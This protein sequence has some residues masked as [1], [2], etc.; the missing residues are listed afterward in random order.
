M[1]FFLRLQRVKCFFLST[2]TF[3]SHWTCVRLYSV[4]AVWIYLMIWCVYLVKIISHQTHVAAI[5][6]CYKRCTAFRALWL[7]E[8]VKWLWRNTIRMKTI[9]THIEVIGND[10]VTFVL[11]F[12]FEQKLISYSITKKKKEKKYVIWHN[13]HLITSSGYYGKLWVAPSCLTEE[14]TGNS[15]N[16]PKL[17]FSVMEYFNSPSLKSLHSPSDKRKSYFSRNTRCPSVCGNPIETNTYNL[18]IHP[19][20]RTRVRCAHFNGFRFNPVRV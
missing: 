14:K 10:N 2:A 16:V 20:N 9:E 7:R 6:G 17:V 1:S 11:W 18:P 5:W 15:R 12:T 13:A 8:P 19:T 4:R 3:T